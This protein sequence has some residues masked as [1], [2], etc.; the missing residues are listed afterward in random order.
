MKQTIKIIM[1]AKI[2]TRHIVLIKSIAPKPY[3]MWLTY[4]RKSFDLYKALISI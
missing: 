1:S 4:N 2:N 3:I